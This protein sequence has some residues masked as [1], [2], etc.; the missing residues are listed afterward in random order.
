MAIAHNDSVIFYL[1]L[2]QQIWAVTADGRWI[3]VSFANLDANIPLFQFDS[4]TLS[5]HDGITFITLADQHY[6]VPSI[7]AEIFSQYA[8]QQNQQE[9]L[10]NNHLD[11]PQQGLNYFY[12]IIKNPDDSLTPE[13]GFTTT[14]LGHSKTS[15]FLQNNEAAEDTFLTLTLTV[16]FDDIDGYIN[17]N[18]TPHTSLNGL[19][20][21]ARNGQALLLTLTDSQ[22]NQLFFTVYVQN[23]MWSISDLDLT[24]LAEGKISATISAPNYPGEVND[25]FD[26]TIKDTLAEISI[27][28]DSGLDSTLNQFEI[29]TVKLSGRVNNIE[30]GQTITI[31]VTDINGKTLSFSTQV[32]DGQWHIDQANLVS[33]ADG[34]LQFSAIVED[35][36]GNSATADIVVDKDTQAIITI[37]AE[38]NDGILNASE[39]AQAVLSGVTSNVED[40]NQVF[41]TITDHLGHQLSF[42]AT[43]TNGVWRL[44]GV[45]LSSLADGELS[46]TATT[47]DFAGNPA[48]ANTQVL[49]DTS[50][51]TIEITIVT[52]NDDTLNEIESPITTIKGNTTDVENGQI[53]TI[54]INDH[55]GNSLTFSAVIHNN[56]WQ[57]DNLDLSS[58]ADGP[59]TATASVAD[60]VGNSA[61]ATDIKNKDVLA[62]IEF[63]PDSQQQ[64]V[65]QQT[66]K[67]ANFSGTVNDVEDGQIILIR[68]TDSNGQQ[69]SFQTLVV[70]GQWQLNGLDLSPLQDGDISV[71]AT[72]TDIYGNH[73][74]TITSLLKDTLADISIEIVDN[75]KVI[76]TDEITHVIIKGTVNNIED[77]QVIYITLTDDNGHS[78]SLQTTVTNG[79]WQLTAQDLT[80]FD[81]GS[82]SATATTTDIA[83]NH[84]SATIKAAIDLLAD[85]TINVATGNDSIINADEMIA[86]ELSGTV[87]EIENGQTVIVTVRDSQGKQLQFSTTVINGSWQINAADL[88]TLADGNLTF[89]ATSIDIAGNSAQAETNAIKDA[90]A[91]ITIEIDSG[92][93]ANLSAAE[94]NNVQVSGRVNNIEV[95][96]TI[97]VTLTDSTGKQLSFQTTVLAGSIWQIPSQD[98]NAQGFSDGPLTAT[99]TSIDAAGNPASATTVA[100]IDTQV[101]IDIDTGTGFNAALF[102]YGVDKQL[103]GSTTEVEAGQTVT[104]TV[105]DGSQT[106]S[107]TTQVKADGSWQ[108]DDIDISGLDT[109]IPWQVSAS[110]IDIAGNSASDQ[111]PQLDIPPTHFLYESILNLIDATGTQ[112]N[113]DIPDANLTISSDQPALTSLTSDGSA[114]ILTVTADGS[115]FTLVK[116]NDPSVMVMSGTLT[117]SQLEIKLFQPIDELGSTSAT[118]FVQMQAQQTD[119]DGT[120][121][122]IITYAVISIQDTPPFAVSDTYNLIEDTSASGSLTANDFTVEGPVS[123]TKIV[124]AGTEYNIPLNGSTNITTP[125]G[126]LNVASNGSWS[127]N[128][129]GN[130]DHSQAQNLQ[131]TYHIV[132]ADGTPATA[133]ATFNI[134]DGAH[135]NMANVTASITEITVDQTNQQSKSFTINAGSDRLDPNSIG[136]DAISVDELQYLGLSSNGIALTYTLSADGK[137]ITASAAGNVVFSLTLSATNNGNDLNATAELQLFRPLDHN[138]NDLL[139]I[140]TKV[141]A[142]DFDGSDINPGQLTWQINDGSNPNI[143]N[144]SQL[145]FNESALTSPLTQQGSFDINIGSD[146]I[147]TNGVGFNS[148]DQQPML[149]A[150]GVAIQ[151]TLSNNGLTLTAHTGDLNSPVFVINLHSGWADNASTIG[152]GY[153]ITLYKAFDQSNGADLHFKIHVTDF[154]GDTTDAS[155]IM[156]VNDDNGATISDVAL[157]VSEQPPINNI[158]DQDQAQININASLDPIV[159]I[160]FDISNGANVLDSS[161]NPITQNGN[162]LTWLVSADGAIIQ[163]VN[164][165]G[166]VVIKLTLPSDIHVDASSTS[167]VNVSLELLGPID[168]L[169]NDTLANLA[170]NVIAIDSDNSQINGVV[171]VTI[172]D[173]ETATLASP[174]TLNIDEAGLVEHGSISSHGVLD[175][176]EGSDAIQQISLADGFTFANHTSDGQTINLSATANNNGWYV[177]HRAGDNAKVFQVRFNADGKVEFKQFKA[178][179]HPA[180]NGENTLDLNFDVTAIDVD[181]DKSAEQ[182]VI[183]TVTDDVPL[184]NNSEF[185]FYEEANGSHSFQLY[186]IAEQ[187]ADGASVTRFNYKGTDYQ[188]GE[189]VNLTTDTGVKYGELTIHA[190]GN[191]TINTVL[192]EYALSQFS[193]EVLITVTDNDGDSV[194]DTLTLTAKDSQ[195]AIFVSKTDFIEDT[196]GELLLFV[197]PGDLDEHEYIDN[198]IFDKTAL[199]GGTLSLNGKELATDAA[200]NYILPKADLVASGLG[201]IP[202]GKLEFTPAEDSSNATANVSLNVTVNIIKDSGAISVDSQVPL[203]VASVADTPTWNNTSEFDYQLNEDAGT[204]ALNLHATSKDEK[205]S[206]SD[207]QSSEIITYEITN[208][209][210]GLILTTVDDAGVNITVTN[211]MLLSQTQIDALTA[212]VG[213]NLAGQFTFN[214]KAISTEPDNN[215]QAFANLETVTINVAPVADKPNLTTRDIHSLEDVAISLDTIISGQLTDNT[216]TLG[217][218]LTLPDGWIIDA[219]S[220]VYLGSNVWTVAG[221]DV[222]SGAAT[223]IPKAD[224]SSANLGPFDISVRS[225]STANAIDGIQPVNDTS[226]P[227]PSYSDLKTVNVT[228]TGVANDKPTIDADPITWAIDENKGII[229]NIKPFSEDSDIPL[230]FLVKSSDDDGS[231][232]VDLKISGIPDGAILVDHNGNPVQLEVVE[233]RNGE[234]VYGVSPALL[235][236]LSLRPAADFSGQLSLILEVTSTELDGDSSENQLTV[237]LTISPVIDANSNSLQTHS[238]GYEDQAI[239]LDL[240]PNLNADRDG[241]ETVTGLTILAP[242]NGLTVLFDG[243][244]ITIPATGLDLNSLID[245]HSPTLASLLQSGRLAVI[246]PEDAAGQFSLDLVYQINDTSST[247]EQISQN[248][249]SQVNISVAAVVDSSTHLQSTEPLLISQDGSAIDLSGQVRFYDDD[250]DGSEVLEYI[251]IVVPSGDGWYINHPNGAISD[252]EGRWLIPTNNLTSSSVQEQ[253]LDILANTSIV[254]DN[255]TGAVTITVEGR[256]K[257]SDDAEII[258]TQFDVQFNVGANDSNAT[259][260]GQLQTSTIDAIEDNSIDFSGHLNLNLTTDTNDEIS[261][262]IKA[263]DLPQGGYFTGADVIA[264]YDATG[265]NVIEWVFSDASLANLQ[266]HNVSKDY[267]G[268]MNIPI[269]I[270]ATDSQSGDTII[271]DSQQLDINISPVI[272]GITLEVG[273]T[274]MLEDQP[275]P[276]SISIN[277]NDSHTSPSTGGQETILLGDSSQPFTIQLIDGGSLIDQSGLFKL[278]SGTTDTYQFVGGNI[279]Q[280]ND[281]LA[282]LEF[283]PPLHVSGTFN[284][285]VSGTVIDTAAIDGNNVSVQGSFS[286][287]ISIDVTPVTDAADLPSSS[288]E[289]TGQ[290]DSLIELSGLATGDIDLI[291]KDGSEVMYLT[292][293]G[294]PT[295]AVL[296]YR[297]GG[298]LIQLP[299]N[300]ADGGN[301]NGSPT[302][303]WTVTPTQLASLVL[304]PPLNFN[305]DIPLTIN[306][307]TQEIGTTDFKGTSTK[308]IIGINPVADGVQIIQQP[309]PHYDAQEG[310]SII[311]DFNAEALDLTGHENLQVTITVSS[312]QASALVDLAGVEIAGQYVNFIKNGAGDYVAVINVTGTSVNQLELFPG[313]LA[314][315]HLDVRLDIASTDSATVIGQHQSD[316]SNSQTIHF[317]IALTPEVDPPIWDQATLHDLN[318]SHN[319]PALLNIE[320]NLQNPAPTETVAITLYGIPDHISLSAGNKQGNKWILTEAELANVRFIG[321]QANDSFTLTLV[322]QTELNGETANAP[323]E[324]INVSF[325]ASYVEVSL[326]SR[327]EWFNQQD[328][329][330]L[331]PYFSGDQIQ[332][333]FDSPNTMMRLSHTEPQTITNKATFDQIEPIALPPQTTIVAPKP[334]DHIMPITPVLETD[335]EQTI[336][337]MPEFDQITP[338]TLPPQTTIVDAKPLDHIMP[339]T[340]VIETD[341]E[342]TI[343][344]KPAFDQIE[345]IILPPQTT[346]VDA[347]PLEH[348]MPITPVI[349]TDAEQVMINKPAFD[350]IE[351]IALPPQTTIID[352]KQFDQITP[353]YDQVNNNEHNQTVEQLAHGIKQ[354]QAQQGSPQYLHSD[355]DEQFTNNQQQELLRIEDEQILQGQS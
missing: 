308:L 233:V 79:T 339:I 185:E 136:F 310:D 158:D 355:I 39:S 141:I 249:S 262:R 149:T 147:A 267:A 234:P 348:I 248:I 35:A 37:Q 261:F 350:Q 271:D 23:E 171:N 97:T 130:I 93:D 3:E 88:S 259:A 55:L 102:V 236:T 70:A 77:G 73:A 94:L 341:T 117:G 215:D 64:T 266:L 275:I 63:L 314:F 242:T 247:G 302:N 2:Q 184:E 280:L 92:S 116:A 14:P 49:K 90:L 231:E 325:D 298:N 52:G 346:I 290:E 238:Q 168:H 103:K 252:G 123:V 188:A 320:V 294:V 305:G 154:D 352:A 253:A 167:Q 219:P 235:A 6:Q 59:I 161:G 269:R 172:Q 76:N 166:N 344:N 65:N 109:L 324:T 9:E 331:D 300:G 187:G 26:Q 313:D 74:T 327:Q 304:Q 128:L 119:A 180:G 316:T 99:A 16:R 178:V 57:L 91:Q 301:F 263:S 228:L 98:L 268:D 245:S 295:G 323:T 139:S 205:T 100:N 343:T 152:Q 260:V 112:I 60:Q 223:L 201:Y 51:V 106:K 334:S 214:I 80:G 177:A 40:G 124:L 264:V 286:D 174:L 19:A 283:S 212:H 160:K 142:K 277:F 1:Q 151:Y 340:P 284:L 285:K 349:E 36:A 258:S 125:Y 50:P 157:T 226:H 227:N 134:A 169:T 34:P 155:L 175:I 209:K 165:E 202:K 38:D 181:N 173:G 218:E 8:K 229:S 29:E 153:D 47:N 191:V 292:I 148:I 186:S 135:G 5:V 342:Q 30:N 319:E 306:A 13:S 282:K 78:V 239:V 291:D 210:T 101:T 189:S 24:S 113:F 251:V 138:S 25:G 11:V 276:L 311:V 108:I 126:S 129:D 44:K 71:S 299:N 107:F 145:T 122:T 53:V 246:A 131:L 62:E 192:F 222:T 120:S 322:A 332:P 190:N 330:Y 68:V 307:I 28:V 105:T 274:S 224:V 95:G 289:I 164:N 81:H 203:T 72:T 61:Y 21:Y 86:V 183:I 7:L 4:D 163:A 338:I 66:S 337:N 75:D 22:G 33:L 85:I 195:G 194:Q 255:V 156:T 162:I 296:Y 317:E 335:T 27:E 265:K 104:I 10:D 179:D 199:A 17:R 345:P 45:D 15:A 232:Q 329:Y 216:E 353:I 133:T 351:P 31:N 272:D 127:F 213:D 118:T 204:L 309:E 111:L 69:L 336:T 144:I 198:I 54:T 176:I 257:D 208:I 41:I 200:G 326:L 315:G 193:E 354:S 297:D 220:A 321:A 32:I 230:D 42:I 318:F 281:A 150:G 278:M 89:S 114:L 241:S 87:N 196:T 240:S 347:K 256:V 83:G 333:I 159:D 328:I 170:I 46:L 20:S 279:A 115:S 206:S 143:T 197:T 243:A 140:S 250:V 207:S 221:T 43:V 244:I 67:A 48:S 270:I 288:I 217:F 254:S 312:S 211:G 12:Q 132:D 146:T 137:I 237:E 121:E 56:Q 293:Q 82:L 225:F 273:Q 287:T 18:E 303:S 84:V 58:L 182:T 96:Q 110:V